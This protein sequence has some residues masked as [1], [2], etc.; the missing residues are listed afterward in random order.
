MLNSVPGAFVNDSNIVS[1]FWKWYNQCNKSSNFDVFNVK[2]FKENYFHEVKKN[3][4][5]FTEKN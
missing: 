5:Y 4:K 2:T 1:F 3:E